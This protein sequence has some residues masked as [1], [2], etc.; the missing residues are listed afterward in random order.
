MPKTTL[1]VGD[2]VMVYEDPL[3]CEKEEG[4]AKLAKFI[5]ADPFR[6]GKERWMVRFGTEGP[7]MRVIDPKHLQR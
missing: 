7:Y 2:R 3:T 1:K 4:V 5:S 6:D